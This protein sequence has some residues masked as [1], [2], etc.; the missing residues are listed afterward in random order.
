MEFHRC[1]RHSP[2]HMHLSHT[3]DRTGLVSRGAHPPGDTSS[4]GDIEMV[5]PNV[6]LQK[7]FWERNNGLVSVKMQ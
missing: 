4:L 2:H 3:R 1:S 5:I 7:V 6:V